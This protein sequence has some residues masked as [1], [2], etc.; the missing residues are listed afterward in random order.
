MEHDPL[1]LTILALDLESGRVHTGEALG[2]EGGVVNEGV[3]ASPNAGHA[4]RVELGVCLAAVL[5]ERV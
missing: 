2:E 5:R 3:R 4:P 1:T